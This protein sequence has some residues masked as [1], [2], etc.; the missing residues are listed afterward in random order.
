MI[1][2]QCRTQNDDDYVFCVN[3]GTPIDSGQLKTE[4]FPSVATVVAKETPAPVPATIQVQQRE[5]E[6]PGGEAKKSSGTFRIVALAAAVLFSLVAI[7]GLVAFF[8]FGR[9]AEPTAQLPEHLGLFA[10]DP[11]SNRL[12]EIAKRE[13]PNVKDGRESVLKDQ[14]ASITASPAEFILYSDPGEIKTDDLKLVR[15]DSITDEGSMRN[16]DFQ[17]VPIE[18][19]PSMKRLKLANPVA[20]GRYAFALF[21]GPFDDGKHKLWPFEIAGVNVTSTDAGRDYTVAL[22]EK[23]AS[24][25]T[26]T[27]GNSNSATVP[28]VAEVPVG[29]RVAYC[30]STDVV[31]RGA[32]SLTARRVNML[33]RGQKIYLLGYSDNYDLWNGVRANWAQIQTDSGKRGW[34]FTPFISY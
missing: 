4:E 21:N 19:K 32:P 26:N 34:V 24:N 2:P 15:I 22:K 7:A 28:T 3:C 11:A 18:N 8:Y 16:F 29:A 25:A 10:V 23:P 17:V 9:K 1:C 27:P 30:N 31:V 33:R 6:E 12:N 20:N 13:F 14:A 5:I